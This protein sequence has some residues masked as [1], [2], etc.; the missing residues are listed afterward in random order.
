MTSQPI[1]AMKPNRCLPVLLALLLLVL[2]APAQA[3][4][5]GPPKRIDYQ[6][7][8]LDS[9]GAPLAPVTPTNYA[10]EF[11][12]YAAQSGGAPIWSESQTVT[13]SNGSFS[14]RLGE[15]IAIGS[16]L[17]GD[18]AAAFNAKDRFLGLTVI[19]PGQTPGEVTPR[20]SFLTSPFSFVAERAKSA[21]SV[22]QA[23]GTSTLGATTVASLT[24]NGTGR[25][26]GNN[27]LEFGAGIAG[28][29]SDAGKIGYGTFTSNTLD[30]VGAGTA[31]GGTDRKIKL[32]A[33]GGLS[34]AGPLTL[35]GN[36]TIASPS[37]LSFGSSIRQMINLWDVTFGLGVQNSTLYSR[38]SSNFA[39][40]VGGSHNDNQNNPGTG[41]TFLASLNSG[42]L[43]L[44]SGSLVIPSGNIGVGTNAPAFRLHVQDPGAHTGRIHVGSRAAGSDAKLISFGD[45]D[46]VT[47]GENG[48]DDR[49]EL[50]A[51]T[52][53]FKNGNVGIGTVTPG[54][55]LDV[56]GFINYDIGG[57]FWFVFQN[58]S[59]QAAPGP[60]VN[61]ISIRASHGILSGAGLYVT[62]DRRIK[63]DFVRS[64]SN[65]DL[66]LLSQ[67]QVTDYGYIDRVNYGEKRKKG[68]LAQE[69]EKVF[70]QAV[71]QHTDVVP[72]IYKK[73]PCK[74]GWVELATDLKKGERVRLIAEKSEGIYEVLEV[75]KDRFQTAFQPEGDSVI[76]FGREVNDFRI[77]DYDAIAVLNVSATQQLKKEKDAEVK[78]LQEENATLKS[79]VEILEARDKARDAKLA[80]IEELL[81][82]NAP[83]KARAVSLKK[84]EGAE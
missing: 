84:A 31:V 22:A 40:F 5:E 14:V 58:E 15:G 6:G 24:V 55:P 62:S 27:A 74:D 21:D 42:G 4:V 23:S 78:A 33:E 8:V 63:K 39:W 1:H 37:S 68:F 47:I 18:L 70:P 26:N 48:A 53:A 30:I 72:D 83:P 59:R 54:V 65:K 12:L 66:D 60:H 36:Q 7:R 64:E 38:S 81:R 41:G 82:S 77:L 57:S 19:I 73:A 61:A 50:T 35:S 13:V 80:A 2:A 34:I 43:Y 20:L 71:N 44:N 49:M 17:H 67:L 52:F 3:Q 28:K 75:E 76:V 56:S 16:E 10:M 11:R 32:W 46:F 79:R 69:V 51:G 25:V 9:A 45:G 29:Q